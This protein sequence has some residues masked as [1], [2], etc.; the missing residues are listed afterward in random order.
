MLIS[1]ALGINEKEH[2]TI[3]G[4]DTVEIAEKF[5]TP[6]YV[7]DEALIRKNCRLYLDSIKK[8]CGE[9]GLALYASKAFSCI[10]ILKVAAEEGMGL[11][12]VSGGELYTAHKADFPMERV[13]FHGNNKTIS[14]LD[15]AL[16]FGVGHIVVD[17]KY[18]LENLNQLASEQNKIA[19]ILFRIKPGVDAHTHDFIRTG[20]IDSKFGFALETG[21]AKEIFEIASNCKNVEI[22]GIHCHIGSQ[23]F[24]CNPFIEAA[25]IMVKFMADVKENFGIKLSQLNLGGGMGIRYTENDDPIGYDCYIE[26]IASTVRKCTEHYGLAMP[27]IIMEPGRSL[28]GSAGITLYN[29]GCVKDIPGVRKY[30]SVDGGMADNP[31]YIMYEAEYTALVANRANAE[32]KDIATIAGKCCESGDILLKDANLPEIEVGDTLAV[33]STGAYN[34]SMSSNYNR[35]PKPPVI[36]IKDG[37]PKVVVKR[38]TY[39]DVLRND[40]Y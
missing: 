20:Q 40:L 14:E 1:E 13:Y 37:N 28:V 35:I 19:K 26:E 7:M 38:E 27:K 36:M 31:R 16:R 11:D 23:I 24:E 30:I 3:G 17:N 10:Y 15:M 39:D 29:V 32:N 9:N 25:E 22:V 21:E 12:V 8:S 34:Y 33:L 6:A 2:L 5:G 4:V 18:E